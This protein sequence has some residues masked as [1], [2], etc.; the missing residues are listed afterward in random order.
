MLSPRA[1]VLLVGQVGLDVCSLRTAS[2]IEHLEPC[3]LLAA[4][5]C[6][7]LYVACADARRD[8]RPLWATT[9][10]SAGRWPLA[11]AK[12]YF[13]LRCL[14]AAPCGQ[15]VSAVTLKPFNPPIRSRVAAHLQA[16]WLCPKRWAVPA[17]R[18]ALVS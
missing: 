7:T 10:E 5:D 2:P 11:A 4:K 14:F 12:W 16:G 3:A 8:N 18:L 9:G 15:P 17:R 13:G 1:L 6:R